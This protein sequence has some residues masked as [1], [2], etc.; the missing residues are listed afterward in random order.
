MAET[1]ELLPQLGRRKPNPIHCLL[2]TAYMQRYTHTNTQIVII[3]IFLLFN[4]AKSL[5]N[6]YADNL[7]SYCL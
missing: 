1:I 6:I 3:K 7:Y 2:T 4:N 5:E